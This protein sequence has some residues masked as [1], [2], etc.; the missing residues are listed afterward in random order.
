M[1]GSFSSREPAVAADAAG[2]DAEPADRVAAWEVDYPEDSI[3]KS[4][5]RNLSEH[6]KLNLSFFSEK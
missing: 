1:A 5:K 2:F 6:D 4:K 3:V